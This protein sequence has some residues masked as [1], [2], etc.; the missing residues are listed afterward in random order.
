[1]EQ[2]NI[3]PKP[4]PPGEGFLIYRVMDTKKFTDYLREFADYIDHMEGIENS[5][6]FIPIDEFYKKYKN[7]L[8]VRAKNTFLSHIEKRKGYTIPKVNQFLRMKSGIRN[9]GKKT[10]KE[11]KG[12]INS[13]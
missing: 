4:A 8:S 7:D 13:K 1:M 6:E 5:D 3:L 12:L 9:F 10:E 11:I 2:R